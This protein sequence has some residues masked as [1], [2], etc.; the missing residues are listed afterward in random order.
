M[1]SLENSGK[2]TDL[3]FIFKIIHF[4]LDCSI[5]L[6]LINSEVPHQTTRQNELFGKNNPVTKTSTI[7]SLSKLLI[8]RKMDLKI[9][10]ILKTYYIIVDATC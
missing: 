6:D 5:L 1:L 3:I 7:K 10:H 2:M 9:Y 4:D 8:L